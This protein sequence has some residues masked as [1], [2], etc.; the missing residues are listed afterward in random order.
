MGAPDTL[1]SVVTDVLWVATGL[2]AQLTGIERFA[3][4]LS[5]A[6][7]TE[8]V[9]VREQLTVVVDE[10][11]RWAGPLEEAGVAVM[12]ERHGRWRRAK[13]CRTPPLVVHNLGG[14]RFPVRVGEA[15]SQTR[16]YSVYDWGPVR[17]STMST[18]ARLAWVAVMAAGIRGA[19]VV[20]YLNSELERTRPRLLPAPTRSIVSYA[21]SALADAAG[22]TT[23][24]ATNGLSRYAFFVG[25]AS[26][27]KRL[28]A[29]AAMARLT[30]T[31]VVMVGAG[32]EAFHGSPHVTALGRVDDVRLRGLLDHC[33]VLILVSAYEG[34]GVPI[35]EAAAR[36]IA[37][38][39]SPEVA[40]T[41][42]A[43]LQ[44]YV[45]V[46]DPSKHVAFGEAITAAAARRGLPRYDSRSIL[47]PLLD[48]YRSSLRR[49]S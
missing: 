2:A 45:H 42:P 40:M 43:D 16:I 31:P 18:K 28:P 19:D 6:L 46:V 9:L 47:R 4:G 32:T 29:V 35:L 23:P 15:P 26:P 7:L 10:R 14:G 33:D 5:E 44:D 11:A 12:R 37:S 41:L 3:L 24:S 1:R 21:N 13:A 22:D 17:D 20:H 49:Y 27:R 25:T 34:F 30:G 36:G 39:V 48:V 38:V 8:G